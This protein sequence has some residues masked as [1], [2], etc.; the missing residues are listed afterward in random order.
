MKCCRASRWRFAWAPP[1]ATSTTPWQFTRRA[2]KNW[3]PCAEAPE[4]AC[5]IRPP[6]S[7]LVAH[8]RFR[9]GVLRQGPQNGLGIGPDSAPEQERLRRLL[10]QHAPSLGGAR[11]MQRFRPQ[12]EGG[13]AAAVRHVVANRLFADETRR[14]F[15][16]FAL[17]TRRSGVDDE[18]VGRTLYIA[19]P[20]ARD[21]SQVGELGRQFARAI[22][23]PIGD[24]YLAQVA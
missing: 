9:L 17:Q 19:E 2:P 10:D 14:H 11:R 8:E 5:P 21:R 4:N 24:D 16:H 23:R 6:S 12:R 7:C 18:V 15:R 13:M 3:S 1:S 20:A 22:R